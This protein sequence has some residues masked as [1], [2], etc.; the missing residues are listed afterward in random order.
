M[1]SAIQDLFSRCGTEQSVMPP[2]QLYNE[3]WMLRLTLDWFDKH[4][5]V[6]HALA[7][8]PGAVWYSEA[9]LPSRFLPT[10]RGDPRSESYTHA[11]GM[12]GHFKVQ[13][14]IRG[15][16]VLE[17]D[18]KQFM[19]IEA[20]L[21]S[22]LS[23]GTKNAPD[24]DQAARNVACMAHMLG[25]ANVH[26]S[27]LNRLAF[28][29][30]APQTQIDSGIFADLVTK[31]SI[32]TK[33][34]TRIASYNGEHDEWFHSIFLPMLEHIE[35]ELLSWEDILEFLSSG[36]AGDELLRKFYEVCLQFSPV[37]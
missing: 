10:F 15:D 7:I 36:S 32:Q 8:A 18:P 6:D 16:A 9:L 19:V 4:R 14:G 37:K 31:Q 23:A 5:D 26:P 2:T 27:S 3:G 12:I 34:A 28:F 17:S 21:G 35:L 20:K 25:V 29:V 22:S 1:L 13:S 11:D 33:V 30:I 24:F